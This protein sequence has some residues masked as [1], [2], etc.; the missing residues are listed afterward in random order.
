MPTCPMHNYDKELKIQ[1]CIGVPQRPQ[2]LHGPDERQ[3]LHTF[4]QE[5]TQTCIGEKKPNKCERIKTSRLR[6]DPI[7]S[8]MLKYF[9]IFDLF[10]C[11]AVC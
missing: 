11:I 5:L 10:H 2:H 4:H 1:Y 9:D 3:A 7:E 8:T 6:D